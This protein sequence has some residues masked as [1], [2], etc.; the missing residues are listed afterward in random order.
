M[1]SEMLSMDYVDEVRDE[2][3]KMRNADFTFNLRLVLKDRDITQC[4]LADI[5]DVS[6]STIK[7]FLKIDNIPGKVDVVKICL[8]LNL[9]KYISDKLLESASHSL[10]KHNKDELI[11]I[12]MLMYGLGCSYPDKLEY[13][14]IQNVFL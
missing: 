6:V 11:I 10:N 7:R 12:N 3:E 8:A 5:M 13:L 2:L 1:W 4:Q 9:P 14:S